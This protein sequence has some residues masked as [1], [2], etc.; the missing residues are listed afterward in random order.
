MSFGGITNVEDWPQTEY[1]LRKSRARY[2]NGEVRIMND[3]ES[4][5]GESR[6]VGELTCQLDLERRRI[7]AVSEWRNK[8]MCLVSL[9]QVVFHLFVKNISFFQVKSVILFLFFENKEYSK[10]V[11]L[12]L[13]YS[14]IE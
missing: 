4:G 3:C 8:G 6:L 12:F 10:K 13:H 9:Q 11:F 1:I 7:R 14:M 2:K 5:K